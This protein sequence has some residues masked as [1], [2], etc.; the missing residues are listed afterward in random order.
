MTRFTSKSAL[1]SLDLPWCPQSSPRASQSLPK[2]LLTSLVPP[3]VFLLQ[4]SSSRIPPP[5]FLP[6]GSSSRI[7]PLGFLQDSSSRVFPPGFLVR[8]SSFRVP[9]QLLLP[10]MSHI[11]SELPPVSLKSADWGH[12]LESYIYICICL[13]HVPQI[14]R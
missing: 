1:G 7:P 4:D 5:G 11:V 3:P 12:T 10:Q 9:P 2:C 13:V 8:D 14:F 6:Q